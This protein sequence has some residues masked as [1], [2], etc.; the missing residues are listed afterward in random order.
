M[1][2]S[3]KHWSRRVLIA[4]LV[5][6][7]FALAGMLFTYAL[8]F[9]LLI[10]AGVLVAIALVR[11][12]RLMSRWTGLSYR[13]AYA[14]VLVLTFLLSGGIIYLVGDSIV[15]HGQKLAAQIGESSDVF[16]ERVRKHPWGKSLLKQ[17]PGLDE[18]AASGEVPQE[19]KDA[20]AEGV[21]SAGGQDQDQDQ[22]RSGGPPAIVRGAM[23]SQGLLPMV[24]TFFSVTASTLG[25]LILVLFLAVY[26]AL[27]PDLY[28]HGM[29]KLAP[30]ERR[31]RFLEVLSLI[32]DTLWW[33]ILG[34]L[35]AMTIIGTLSTL[36]LW[37]IGIPMALPLGVLAGLLNFVPNIGPT[38]ALVPPLLFGLQQGTSSAI[39]VFALYMVLQFIETY[40][41]TPVIEQRQVSLPP[42]V[43]IPVQALFGLTVGVFGLLMATPAAAVVM[44]G[45]REYYVKD[46]L[47]DYECDDPH[48]LDQDEVS[49][50]A[51]ENGRE[52]K[53]DGGKTQGAAS[54][55]A[56]QN[57]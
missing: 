19:V 14:I 15:Q 24:G 8:N 5:L 3:D 21:R 10:L 18:A 40:I 25:S 45:V 30:I 52:G 47:G 43:T 55:S 6:S 51:A 33:W 54:A 39:Y 34:R 50:E 31:Q 12:T 16:L 53:A 42:G 37:M 9:I 7:L 13:Y 49:E 26:F 11:A 56:R 57:E 36:G 48:A 2:T 38:I 22:E 44:V 27:D 23:R 32:S 46:W 29:A 4:G 41:I 20:A 17:F 35:L 28:A 1:Q